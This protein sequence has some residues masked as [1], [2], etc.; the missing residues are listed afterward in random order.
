MPAAR[1]FNSLL[2]LS[3]AALFGALAAGT[4]TAAPTKYP[5]TLENCRETITFNAAPKRVVAIGQTQT[6]ILYALGLGDRLVGTA[7]WFSPVAKPY[8]AVNAKVKRLADNDPSFEAVLAQEPDLVTAM[9]EWHVGPNGIVG[10]RD[11]FAKVKVPAYVSPTDCV[12]KDNSGAGDGVRTQMF[13][14]DLV[15]RNI[16]E[17]GEIF[18]VADRAEK[19]VAELKAREDKAVEQVAKLKAQDVPV[20]V[21]FSSKDIKGDGFMAGKNGVPAYILSKLGARNIIAT[22][23]EW[24]LVG[25]E[26]I[27]AANP[28]VIVTV[29]MDRRRFPADD[30]EKKLEFLKTDPVASKLDAVRN[31]RVVILDVGA[32]RAGLDTVDGI[33]TLAKAIAG[34]GISR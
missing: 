12:G 9:F 27:A 10:K 29:K 32:T 5:L 20:V 15:Y 23:E 30:I 2:R 28:A 26:S 24:P 8:E 13:T 21:W 25:W 33:E 7:V 14:M 4:A 34:F 3:A 18:D 6:E 22:N 31:N 11:Q 16:R 17:F 19:L 1:P